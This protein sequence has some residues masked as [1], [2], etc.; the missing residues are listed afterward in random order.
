MSN[1][2]S[3]LSF[4][5]HFCFSQATLDGTIPE[6]SPS[7][8]R[9]PA[10]WLLSNGLPSLDLVDPVVRIGYKL[11]LP[12]IVYKKLNRIT[13]GETEIRLDTEIF[14]SVEKDLP[15]RPPLIVGGSD[16][17][18]AGSFFLN[19]TFSH[20]NW[21]ESSHEG[22]FWASLDASSSDGTSTPNLSLHSTDVKMYDDEPRESRSSLSSLLPFSL[23]RGQGG[24]VTNLYLYLFD[25]SGLSRCCV[26][27]RLL[28]V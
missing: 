3:N 13:L 14:S 24:H 20:S 23:S 19:S 8:L 22:G 15:I 1:G 2:C 17:K 9:S 7:N 25:L 21:G 4:L 6:F 16:I 18:F 10:L 11:T 28:R 27:V 12:F 26:F 5:F